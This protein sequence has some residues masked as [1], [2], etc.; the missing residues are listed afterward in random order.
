MGG[1][2]GAA[3]QSASLDALASAI[4][5]STGTA[6]RTICQLL[7]LPFQSLLIRVIR[8]EES[9]DLWEEE[10]QPVIMQTFDRNAPH[11]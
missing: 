2:T 7:F 4:R 6:K 9:L 11:P 1:L 5:P 8:F 3:R 10:H